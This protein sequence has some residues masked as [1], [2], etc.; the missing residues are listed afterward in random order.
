MVLS[1]NN[2]VCI[3]YSKLSLKSIA[4]IIEKHGTLCYMRVLY[5]N[6]KE[7]NNTIIIIDHQTYKIIRKKNLLNIRIFV[8]DDCNLPTSSVSNSS[9]YIPVP[10]ILLDHEKYVTKTIK[11]KLRHI[12]N[13]GIIPKNTWNIV[14]PLSSRELGTIKHGCFI[15]FTNVSIETLAMIRILLT[16]TYWTNDNTIIFNALWARCNNY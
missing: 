7:T 9:L 13:I 5:K 6:N 3:V 14:C 12:E 8:I 11:T 10:K 4:D 2:V 1:Y 15:N 16:D